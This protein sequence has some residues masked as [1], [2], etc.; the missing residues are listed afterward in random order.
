MFDWMQLCCLVVCLWFAAPRLNWFFPFK[1]K[2]P[3]DD[4]AV[5]N[6]STSFYLCACVC[7]SVSVCVLIIHSLDVFSDETFGCDS[8]RELKLPR[9]HS[10]RPIRSAAVRLVRQRETLLCLCSWSLSVI[11]WCIAASCNS[12]KA[13]MT[14]TP[15]L[16]FKLISLA[17]TRIA[18][19]SIL[20]EFSG[21]I[22]PLWN[23]ELHLILDRKLFYIGC[24][25]F[26]IGPVHG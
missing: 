15:T 8:S 12:C 19:V 13:N 2:R 16:H 1:L 20:W 23:L 22:C 9:S 11:K 6:W 10:S 14:I 18:F 24:C 25:L 4:S 21:G 7:V 17:S 5:G 3:A 26:L